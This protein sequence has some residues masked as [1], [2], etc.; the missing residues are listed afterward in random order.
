MTI[1]IVEDQLPLAQLICNL[2]GPLADE[3]PVIAGTLPEAMRILKGKK[4]DMI[5]LD[6]R[7]PGSSAD[8]TLAKIVDMR[9]MNDPGLVIVVTGVSD[10]DIAE[11]ALAAGAHGFIYKPAVSHRD[12]LFDNLRAL[13]LSLTRQPTKYQANLEL[14]EKLI[15]KLSPFQAVVDQKVTPPESGDTAGV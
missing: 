14:A 7:L 10:P 6:L 4:F 8:Q 11:K 1:L 12:T 3:T 5:T 15:A 9:K 13:A 2:L